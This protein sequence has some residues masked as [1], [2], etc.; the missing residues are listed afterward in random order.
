[1]GFDRTGGWGIFDAPEPWGPWT[2]AFYTEQWD[3]GNT[4]SYRLPSKWI[5]ADNKTMYVVFSGKT[6]DGMRYDAF[7]VRKLDL[8]TSTGG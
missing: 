8:T 3:V 2:T 6:H 5:G 4:H 7:S 1:M